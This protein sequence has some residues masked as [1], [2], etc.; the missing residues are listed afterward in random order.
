MI[1]VNYSPIAFLV[2]SF[3]QTNDYERKASLRIQTSKTQY[4]LCACNA[5]A[6]HC[7]WLAVPTLQVAINRIKSS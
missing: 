7:Y 2:T 1:L 5:Q 3:A 4:S 6:N